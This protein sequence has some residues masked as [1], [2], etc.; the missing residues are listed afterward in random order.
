MNGCKRTFNFRNPV[1]FDHRRNV[2]FG[3]R[4]VRL[5]RGCAPA[6]QLDSPGRVPP[7][8]RP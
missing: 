6:A 7:L 4:H 8:C 3:Q 5:R 1:S 2:K